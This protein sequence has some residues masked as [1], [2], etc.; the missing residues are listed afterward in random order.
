MK[1]I[2]KNM[3]S[4]CILHSAGVFT[5]RPFVFCACISFLLLI[6]CIFSNFYIRLSCA[7]VCILCGIYFIAR[8]KTYSK[9]GAYSRTIYV[10]AA[11]MS[12][13]L[14]A[15]TLY[16]FDIRGAECEKFIS[17]RSEISAY[18]VPDGNSKIMITSIDGEE[19]SYYATLYG[20]YLPDFYEEFTC[21][22]K[23]N[24]VKASSLSD[25]TYRI[26][27]NIS[28]TVKAEEI[29]RSG[30]LAKTPYAEFYKAN[31][32]IRS[33]IYKH[34]E[35]YPGMIS[36]IFLGN[37]ADIPSAV[38]ADF[39]K[40]GISHI[41]AVSGLHVIAAL[42]LLSFI[43]NKTVPHIS[44]R[45]LI[46][47][48]AAL[49]YALI[50]GCV[51]SVMRAA[52]MYTVLNLSTVLF[53]K[54]DS[55]T[56]LFISLYLIFLFEPYAVLNLSLQLSAVSTFGIVVFAAPVCKRIDSS[57]L[58]SER[59]GIKLIA[60]Y[61][62]KSLMISA[63]ATLPLIPISAY[64]F[65]KISLISPLMTLLISP[66]VLLIL[67]AAP[68]TAL[69]GFS[70]ALADL[71]GQ[72]CDSCAKIS[73]DIASFGAHHLNFEV[74][75]EY[76][77]APVI[78]LTFCIL[79]A[80]LI[81]SGIRKKCIYAILCAVF[82]S[83]YSVSAVVYHSAHKTD[84]ELIY[85]CVYDDVLCRVNGNRAVAVDITNGSDSSYE[86]LFSELRKRGILELDTLILT[87]CG[88]DHATLIRNI[89]AD[90]GIENIILPEK[91]RY[92]EHVSVTAEEL[93]IAYSFYDAESIFS[94]KSEQLTIIPA[95]YTDEPRSCNIKWNGAVYTSGRTFDIDMQDTVSLFLY[96]TFSNVSENAVEL[97]ENTKLAIIPIEI[98]EN[99]FLPSEFEEYSKLVNVEVFESITVA[100]MKKYS[101]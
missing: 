75:L 93:D 9:F 28:F 33:S 29:Q 63:C 24:T 55:L 11:F 7:L 19:V 52:V 1:S 34:C 88:E 8:R 46:L 92:T 2:F 66:F 84:D 81:L 62:L 97:I 27:N 18:A 90:Y 65:G 94:L 6:I 22:G 20:A 14:C 23:I 91:D 95:Y 87:R 31:R 38:N 40:T 83:V 80:I 17:D 59:N 96:G 15:R 76:V 47:I 3:K 50:T 4:N 35:E 32:Y 100:D 98:K 56:S 73:I 60:K 16:H 74:S 86:L 70:D 68:L 78:I 5:G 42:A 12:L 30:E 48:F 72:L 77:F 85:S 44:I 64:Y 36:R 26:G 45:A 39:L 82:I 61:S 69:L 53:R 54:N 57:S 101:E 25:S 49:F 71:A 51:Y 58:F 89:Y 10:I 13:I 37:R 21:F 41:I 79:T 99:I 67:Y 43:L